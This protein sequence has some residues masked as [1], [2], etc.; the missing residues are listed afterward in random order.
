MIKYVSCMNVG[1]I[2][3]EHQ[4]SQESRD[5]SELWLLSLKIYVILS[6][7][8]R[9]R[10]IDNKKGDSSSMNGSLNI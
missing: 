7:Q 8:R 2:L 1:R 6:L 5:T 10:K 3:T 9:R 4:L